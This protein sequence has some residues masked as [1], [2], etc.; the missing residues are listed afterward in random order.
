[1][2]NQ[3]EIRFISAT[4]DALYSVKN[5]TLCFGLKFQYYHFKIIIEHKQ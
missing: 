3:N 5:Y 1:M 4:E 2:E